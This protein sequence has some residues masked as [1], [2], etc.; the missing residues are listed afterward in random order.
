MIFTPH[1]Y[2]DVAI[3][4]LL[5][6]LYA[7]EQKGAGLFLDPGLGKTSITLATIAALRAFGEVRKTLIVAPLRVVHSVW[8]AEVA[9]WGF[10]LRAMIVHGT[11][12]KRLRALFADA[13][14]Y[15]I[16]PEALPWLAMQQLPAFDLVVFDESPKF[17]TWGAKRTKA[18]KALI[19]A[20]PRRVI[21][22]GTPAPNSLADLFAQIYMLDDGAT[23]GKTIT[24]FRSRFMQQGGYLGREWLIREGV[25]GDIEKAIAP[26]VLRL[27]AED[28]L[29][30]PRLLKHE[31][32]VD[33]PAEIAKAYK[34]VEREL[35]AALANGETLTAS[36]AGAKHVLCR[37]IANGG[38]YVDDGDGTERRPIHVHDAKIEAVADIVD[39]L[40]G[41]PVLVAYQFDHD[42]ARLRR[43]F[44]RAPLIKGKG[45]RRGGEKGP[46]DA[47]C[48]QIVADWNA[49]KIH[50]L[51]C[52]PQAMSH[53]LNMQSGPGRDVVWI[54]P[55]DSPEIDDQLNRRIYRQGVGSQVRIHYVMA[56][57]T[58]DVASWQ[59]LQDKGANQKSLLD[60][61]NEYRKGAS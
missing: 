56:R 37:G 49:G 55:S 52:Q 24:F 10:D 50:V 27:A 21:L 30:M 22:T 57:N 18:A 36:G 9:K 17:K 34:Q 7:E 40:G 48:N 35:F 1:K 53:G 61:L 25:T 46:T 4:F 54:G 28:H 29:D 60:A 15:M 20:I 12:K 41:K 14:L 8:P 16:N 31:V 38:A 59:R 47:E 51:L 23:L 13:D 58:V 33:L 42:L 32:W 5:A 45:S 3:N 43:H 44:P 2:Q 6:R 39:E 11:P 19:K 26:L